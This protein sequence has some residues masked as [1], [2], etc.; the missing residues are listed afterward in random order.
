M[1]A[2]R[3][4]KRFQSTY[5]AIYLQ[6]FYLKHN[7]DQCWPSPRF[8]FCFARYTWRFIKLAVHVQLCPGYFNITILKTIPNTY[9]M[10][11]KVAFTQKYTDTV[12]QKF[13]WAT[14]RSF[15]FFSAKSETFALHSVRPEGVHVHE[16]TD[17]R[18]EFLR[19]QSNNLLSRNPFDWW[20]FSK[21]SV[22]VLF[23]FFRNSSRDSIL[24]SVS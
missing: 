17:G 16:S 10:I 9:F 14:H 11:H 1:R 23:C 2:C 8:M 15:F 22:F 4:I 7:V 6:V 13:R 3:S 24:T 12:V 18:S 5:Y 19:V 20:I 21:N